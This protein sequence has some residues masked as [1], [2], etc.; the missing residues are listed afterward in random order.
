MRAT[1]TDA[2]EMV[3]VVRQTARSVL[4]HV[5][6]T[7]PAGSNAADKQ[8]RLASALDAV[9]AA[10]GALDDGRCDGPVTSEPDAIIDYP[11][12]V[13]RAHGLLPAIRD[14]HDPPPS[15]D[16]SSSLLAVA[17]AYSPR[18]LQE[19]ASAALELSVRV[20]DSPDAAL[21]L[22]VAGSF[23]AVVAVASQGEAWIPVRVAVG[24]SHHGMPGGALQVP[25]LL[26][27]HDVTAR[28]GALIAALDQLAPQRRLH[29]LIAWLCSLHNLFDTRCDGCDAVFA[30]SAAV[31]SDL[32]PPT[33][34]DARLR[35]WHACCFT[36][37]HGYTAE[38][39]CLDAWT[40][41]S[42]PESL[43]RPRECGEVAES[44][45]RSGQ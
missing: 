37:Q 20:R 21:E 13:W 16:L 14:R 41:G 45:W 10:C 3:G 27:Y 2:A 31:G 6:T 22:C 7:V 43:E 26:V 34:R 17:E 25:T 42:M 9:Q 15:A 44:S 29:L 8:L 24:P 4:A 19:R 11:S 23:R 38:A 39:S 28:A 36:A 32:L 35:P 5:A 1:A 40:N 30:P 12:R 33:A 18:W